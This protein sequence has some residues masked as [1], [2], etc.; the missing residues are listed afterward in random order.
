MRLSDRGVRLIALRA[1]AV[2]SGVEPPPEGLSA[3]D[4]GV[5]DRL[6]GSLAEWLPLV[7][8]VP[9]SE[10]LDRI[11]T[12]AAYAF[13]LRGARFAQARENLKKIRAMAR[14]LQN[15]GYATMAR[16]AEHLARL[17]AGDESNAVVDA[18]DSVNLMTVHAAKGLEFPIVFVT[19]LDR[20]TGGHGDPVVIVPAGAGGRQLVSVGGSLPEADEAVRGRDREETKR[21][22]YV[23]VTR[24][25]ERLYLGAVLKDGSFQARPGSLGEVLPA[26]LRDAFTRAATGGGSVEWRPE[27]GSAHLLGV[28]QP[29]PGG[30]PPRATDGEDTAAAPPP[31]VVDIDPLTD[32][33]GDW[34]VGAAA[35]ARSLTPGFA[36]EPGEPADEP[37]GLDPALVG[38]IVHRLFQVSRDDATCETGWLTAR[39]R[40]FVTGRDV[41]AGADSAEVVATAV[42]AF[43][44][45][46]RRT[47]V[48]AL[49][50]DAVCEYEL[51]FSLRL[52]APGGSGRTG[53]PVV[54]RGSIDCLA[55]RPDGTITVLELK[56]GRRRD[57][58]QRQL[59]LY[60]RAARCLFPGVAVEGRL[61]YLEEGESTSSSI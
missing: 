5:L 30:S 35:Y 58:H 16:V 54:V 56:T 15:R 13:E 47:D 10:V 11:V 61:V 12:D 38:T 51:P 55:R 43:L 6:R 26:S 37:A 28:A 50:D 23:A 39:A 29:D 3:E 49:V 2:L 4:R 46:R 60:V 41:A 1:E 31:P 59:D 53:P 24:A 25:R 20:G 57:W 48:A 27:H 19:N 18:L 40:A 7:D 34:R 44:R 22:L 42:D 8:R 36:G 45:L 14:R 17:S 33:I 52:E 32:T 21:L 9:P